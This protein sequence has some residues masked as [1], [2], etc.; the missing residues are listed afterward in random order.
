[1]LG[2]LLQAYADPGRG[3]HDQEH[4]REVLERV[5]ELAAADPRPLDL[6]VIRLA[7]FFHDAVYR[8]GPPEPDG[9]D[10]RPSNEEA[11]AR[12]AERALGH[13]PQLAARVAGLV[14][15]TTTHEA[16]SDD[17]EAAVLLDADLAILAAPP[18]RYARYVAGVR[19]EYAWVAVPDFR[20]GRARVLRDLASRERIFRTAYARARW[21]GPARANLAAELDDLETPKNDR[22]G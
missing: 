7:A 9:A 1:M 4:L 2:E 16:P 13:E 10:A 20:A 18:E 14:R 12:W 17:A 19:R 22:D 3:Y 6:D 5:D 8:T 21:E 11:S 15:A